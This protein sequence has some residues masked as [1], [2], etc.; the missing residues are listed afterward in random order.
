MSYKGYTIFLL[1]SVIVIFGGILFIR[2]ALQSDKSEVICFDIDNEGIP[3]FINA[4]FI[5]LDKI[6]YVKRFR[7][8]LGINYHDSFENC[9]SLSHNFYAFE[10]YQVEQNIKIFSPINGTITAIEGSWMNNSGIWEP[11][12]S[13]LIKKITIQSSEYPAFSVTIS[14]VDIR[15]MGLNTEMKVLAG[16]QLGYSNTDVINSVTNLNS[17]KIVVNTII[18][19][20]DHKKL[21]YFDVITDNL[22][23][24]YKDRGA[25]TREDFIISKEERD[26]DP[27]ECTFDYIANAEFIN[28]KGN[29]PNWIYLGDN[30]NDFEIV[31]DYT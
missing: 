15:E 29:L 25:T 6:E 19:P 12:E 21:S 2:F 30:P 27:L 10:E 16:Q 8:G 18:C 17:I 14:F 24:D 7:S 23:E 20:S 9:R 22:F 28:Q 1:L 26:L 13:N 11:T 5:E 4:H 3:K 31:Y